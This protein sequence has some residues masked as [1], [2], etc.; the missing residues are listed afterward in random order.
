MQH[1][2]FVGSWHYSAV[3]C[4][5]M[6]LGQ[7]GWGR[8]P[9]Y[10]ANVMG[11][12]AGLQYRRSGQSILLRQGP[13]SPTDCL[14][15]GLTTLGIRVERQSGPRKNTGYEPLLATLLE[16]IQR[17]AVIIGPVAREALPYRCCAPDLQHSQLHYV[18]AL[19]A[20]SEQAVVHDPEGYAYASLPTAQLLMA[21]LASTDDGQA[22]WMMYRIV[23]RGSQPDPA[24]ILAATLRQALLISLGNPDGTQPAEGGS[25][26][27]LHRL[28]QDIMAGCEQPYSGALRDALSYW[29]AAT[30]YLSTARF[31]KE[32][33]LSD[34]A[35]IRSQQA[36]I[37]GA[38]RTQIGSRSW[39]EIGAMVAKLATLE[40]Q[41]IA[42][43]QYVLT[44]TGQKEIQV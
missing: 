19:Q 25:V 10:L 2:I 14:D 43:L 12:T 5:S 28:H 24:T 40:Q 17:G 22:S 8:P 30:G 33:G 27:A 34:L 41:W 35:R 31:L 13:P 16:Q 4:L 39:Q 42:A 21:C 7:F 1:D 9:H 44:S 6:A 23:E 15:H 32:E 20:D 18:L 36:Q 29:D 38:V 26:A 3:N 37:A 11:A